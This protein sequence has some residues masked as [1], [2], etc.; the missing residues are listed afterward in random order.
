M[1][2]ASREG[3]RVAKVSDS[4]YRNGGGGEGWGLY[5]DGVVVM[6]VVMVVVVVVVGGRAVMGDGDW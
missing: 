6:V 2:G 1:S 3:K 4:T 5:G